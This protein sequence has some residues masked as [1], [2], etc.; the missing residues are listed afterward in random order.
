[1]H[2]RK[3]M[4]ALILLVMPLLLTG[5]L[6][7]FPTEK[8]S[9]EVVLVPT[10]I[11]QPSYVERGPLVIN[12]DSHLLDLDGTYLWDGDGSFGSPI[13]IEGYNITSDADCLVI[14]IVSLYFEVRDCYFDSVS[15]TPWTI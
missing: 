6:T 4:L 11:S 8:A 1:M 7:T 14:G 12:N 15:V 5:V 10:R 13:I 9:S 3:A 2:T